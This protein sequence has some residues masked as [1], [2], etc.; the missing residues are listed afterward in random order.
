MVNQK[1]DRAGVRQRAP[2]GNPLEGSFYFSWQLSPGRGRRHSLSR[3]LSLSCTHTYMHA[4]FLSP[5]V[6]QPDSPTVNI[7]SRLFYLQGIN[8]PSI[9][10]AGARPITVSEHLCL[11]P[12]SGDDGG[13]RL[14]SEASFLTTVFSYPSATG[15][16][17]MTAID[18]LAPPR[19][20]CSSTFPKRRAFK[21]TGHKVQ[22]SW[23]RLVSTFIEGQV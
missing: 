5:S 13:A 6:H 12:R 1:S 17:A 22:R 7:Y 14:P 16:G 23:T 18:V 4:Q 8:S 21:S 10:S 19:G 15:A 11:F 3:S 2:D 9:C 20:T